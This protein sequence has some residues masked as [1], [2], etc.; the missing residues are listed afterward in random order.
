MRPYDRGGV[1]HAVC[2]MLVAFGDDPEREGIIGTP[3]RVARAWGEMLSGYREDP[4]AILSTD[5]DADGYDQMV[6]LRDIDFTSMC[7]HHLLPFH[8]IAHVAY[9][10][11]VRV[12][13]LSKLARLVECYARRLQLQEKMTRQV[14]DALQEHLVPLGVAVLVEATHTCMSDRGV[15]KP[16]AKMV[17]SVMLGALRHDPGA[18]A[19]FLSLVKR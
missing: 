1:E 2:E 8:G 5:F 13:G 11:K 14:A 6:V 12:V 15:K 18:R 7:E 16:G 17:T 10:P 3:D 9:I 19:E 4:R